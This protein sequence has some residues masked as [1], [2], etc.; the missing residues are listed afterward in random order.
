MERRPEIRC[1]VVEPT[2][3][4]AIAGQA[5]TRPD[6]PIQGGGYARTALPLLDRSLIDGFLQ[7]PGGSPRP[8]SG[9]SPGRRVSSPAIHP[10]R[11]SRR[12]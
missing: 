2:G 4:A 5:V 11:M 8:A 1:Y 3:A 10:V 6:H 9:S 12:R 7:V